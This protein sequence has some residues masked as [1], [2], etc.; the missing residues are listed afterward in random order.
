M[1]KAGYKHTEIG[2]IP[3]DWAV[4]SL[5]DKADVFRGGSPRPIQD[6][7]TNASGGLNWIKIGDVKPEEKYIA[8][9]QEK[10]IPEGLSKTREVHRGD[11]LLSN[12][13][14]F[15][16]PCLLEIDGCIHDGW[17]TI[18]NYDASFDSEF[19]YYYL[20][21][22]I[23]IA[24]YNS[25][26]AGSGVKNLNKD[27]V[28]SV[29]IVNPENAEQKAIAATLSDI[30]NLIVNLEKLI[31]KKR[32]IKLGAMQEL[33]TANRRL[34]GYREQWRTYSLKEIG[35][36][37]TGATPS[38]RIP[39]YWGGAFNWISAQDF[40]KKYIS[41]S[42][43]KVT[44]EGKKVCRLLP[45]GTVLVTCIASIGLNAI[46]T[47]ECATNQQINAIVCNEKF[48]NEFI[49][50]AICFNA[51][52][53]MQIAGQTAVPIINKTQ[54]ENFEILV[55]TNIDEQIEISVILSDMDS[56]IEELETKL[57]KYKSIKVGM[58][59]EL[60]TGRI[61]LIDQEEA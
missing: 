54:F 21:S 10:I 46:A 11:L 50:Y 61:R 12:S 44:V 26:A 9:T 22:E 1:V 43:E 18:Q 58:M 40:R 47:V 34:P 35:K 30:D 6:Y 7:L 8:S 24:Q 57:E 38:R 41:N 16:R 48:D 49:Y 53:M 13:M 20:S 28:A 15:G 32:V 52:K 2:I 19:L 51:Y 37:V 4:C 27:K 25:M 5:G 45:A 23:V 55:P 36:I 14:S 59:S 39:E 42:I 60:L 56:E 3:E 29:L 33:L 31:E 17:L